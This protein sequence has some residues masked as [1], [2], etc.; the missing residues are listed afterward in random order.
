MPNI[1]PILQLGATAIVA[2]IGFWAVVQVVKLKKN[3]KNGKNGNGT[4]LKAIENMKT[5]HLGEVNN[6]LDRLA[7]RT[8]KIVELL[9]RIESLLRK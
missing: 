5:N 9:I 6:K 2:I 7:N 3:G 8:D 1:S 4:I